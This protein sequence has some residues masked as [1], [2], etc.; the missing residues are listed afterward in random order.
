MTTNTDNPPLTGSGMSGGDKQQR[1]SSQGIP[2]EALWNVIHKYFKDDP[3]ALVKHHIDSYDD[4][5]ESGLHKIIKENNPIRIRK[6]FNESYDEHDL[7]IDVYLGGIDGNKIFYGKPIIHEDDKNRF[8]FPNEARLRNMNY[9]TNVHVDVEFHFRLKNDTDITETLQQQAQDQNQDQ[10]NDAQKESYETMQKDPEFIAL[11]EENPRIQEYSK[12]VMEKVLLGRFPVM[13]HSKLCILRDLPSVVAFQMGECKNDKG[14]YFIVDGREKAIIP[15]EKFA[16]NMMYIR[17][18]ND[19]QNK[20]RTSCIMRTVS[21]NASKPERT[22]KVSVVSPTDKFTHMNIVVDVPNIRAPIPLFILMRALG[23]IT[24]KEIIEICLL[25]MEKNKHMMEHFRPCVHDAG[26]IFSQEDAL[27]FLAKLTKRHS[28]YGVHD[29]LMNYFLP[30]VG[31]DNYITKAYFLGH[32]VFELL[33]VDHNIKP[34]TDRDSFKFKRLELTGD[35]L[36]GLTKEYYKLQLQHVFQKLDKEIYYQHNKITKDDLKSRKRRSDIQRKILSSTQDVITMNKQGFEDLIHMNK[37]DLFKERVLES[38]IKK[39]MKGNWGASAHTK[40]LGIVQVFNRLSFNS[41]LSMLRKVNLPLDASA[42]VVGPRLLHSSQYGIIDGIDTPDGGNIGL[43]KHLAIM[44]H[45]SRHI[46]LEKMIKWLQQTMPYYYYETESPEYIE[47][48]TKLFVNGQW[49]GILLKPFHYVERFKAYRRLGCLPWSVSI[50]FNIAQNKIDIFCDAGRLS[51]PIYYSN[52]HM[53]LVEND[54]LKYNT[55]LDAAQRNGKGIQAKNYLSLTKNTELYEKVVAN[56]FTWS[57]VVRGVLKPQIELDETHADSTQLYT[58]SSLYGEKHEHKY[59]ANISEPLPSKYTEKCGIIDFVDTNECETSMM[60]TYVDEYMNAFTPGSE[61]GPAQLFTHVELHPSINF[62]IMGNQI[63]YAENNPV[64]RNSFSCGQTKQAVSLYHSNFDNRFD[65]MG[66][67]L[68]YGQVPLIKSRYL[69]HIQNEEHPYGENTIVAIMSYS[70]YNVEDAVL[71]NKAAVERGLFRTTYYSTVETR[72][73]ST[74]VAGATKD[75]MFYNVGNDTHVDGKRSWYDFSQ[76]DD[77]GIVKEGTVLH[78]H[79]VLVGKVIKDPESEQL[80]DDSVYAKKGMSGTVDKVFVSHDEEGFRIAKIRI[81]QERIPAIGDKMASRAGQKGT[82]GILVP[83]EDM[84][85]TR[86]GIVP[87]II[88][89]PHAIPS[90]M[91]LGQLVEMLFGKS[92]LHRGGFGDCTPFVNQGPKNMTYGAMLENYGYSKTG[93]EVLYS[94]FTGDQLTSDIFIGPTYYMRLK[95]MVKDKI[96]HRARGPRQ[97]LTRQTVQGRANEGGLR[98]GEMERDGVIAHGATAFLRESFM[99]RGDE[100]KMA[101]CNNSGTIAVYNVETKQFYSLYA[102]GHMKFNDAV[103]IEN[104][105]TQSVSKHGRDFTFVNIPYSLKLLIQELQTM[106]VQM[107]LITDDNMDQN[108]SLLGQGSEPTNLQKLT[109][110]N[111]MTFQKYT[112]VVADKI[113]N[114]MQHQSQPIDVFG[115]SKYGK[116]HVT[117]P[118]SSTL[119]TPDS[120]TPS[121]GPDVFGFSMPDTPPYAPEQEPEQEPEH[122]ESYIKRTTANSNESAAWVPASSPIT[123]SNTPPTPPTSSTPMSDV[124][125][126][127][128]ENTMVPIDLSTLK[129]NMDAVNSVSIL[130]PDDANVN[131][132]AAPNAAPNAKQNANTEIKTTS[133]LGVNEIDI[134]NGGSENS[135]NNE[136]NDN[137]VYGTG[138]TKEIKIVKT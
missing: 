10:E 18:I 105:K 2:E 69:Q 36:F 99:V 77:N 64:T 80:V 12:I 103:D 22:L 33:Q 100:Y 121:T 130:E 127:N 50:S 71:I 28:V 101:I 116:Q 20:Y 67:I 86:G 93:T 15:Q 95:H 124:G 14:G 17:K 107:R 58:L 135:K 38:G 119:Y 11:K 110:D 35:L 60:A 78:E 91:T 47:S 23:V 41:A 72:E 122:D 8:L 59:I 45:V 90:R 34:E 21:E 138:A 126:M 125:V 7:E 61:S 120:S 128:A 39:A 48:K 63:I 16:D 26:M 31:E 137:N 13:L 51:R 102:D 112:S 123:P 87:D 68:N 94:G 49:V 53:Q 98:I 109:H 19:D 27:D 30:N 73:E 57:Q 6:N 29:I 83:H 56:D 46:S 113:E 74:E 75:A 88:I 25:D 42:K 89:N 37:D 92:L 79:S 4:F 65:K 55:H 114:S 133:T 76:L 85:F 82:I 108:E 106:N 70:G 136:T 24:D 132:N 115:V 52:T 9:A 54:F 84:P 81:R 118:D 40:R 131:S 96:N 32:M 134:G 129:D 97:L 43:H 104:M 111:N 117:T 66:V 3:H 44:A 5:M 1:H 62:G